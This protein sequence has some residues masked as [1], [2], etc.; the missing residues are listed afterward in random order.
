MQKHHSFRLKPLAAATSAALLVGFGASAVR[1]ADNLPD[2]GS[3]GEQPWRVDTFYENDTH[4]RR[5]VGLSKFRN[6]IQIEADKD[7]GGNGTFSSIKL[8]TKFRGTYDGVYKLNDDEYGK[9]A[10]GPILL[11]SAAIGP[12]PG[13]LVPHG[14]SFAP[15]GTPVGL[16]N[17]AG[18]LANNPNDGMIVLGSNLHKTKGGVAFGGPQAPSDYARRGCIKD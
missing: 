5:D 2:L 3:S 10:G 18:V 15:P 7:F 14:G 6:T 9:N 16:F 12:F 11:E 4:A 8:R 1:A 17:S 13:G